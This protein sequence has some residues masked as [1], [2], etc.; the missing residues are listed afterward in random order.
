M[1]LT[2]PKFFRPSVKQ[3]EKVQNQAIKNVQALQNQVILEIL[4]TIIEDV[5]TALNSY[6][7]EKVVKILQDIILYDLNMR[8]IISGQL[9]EKITLSDQTLKNSIELESYYNLARSKILIIL[10]DNIL[11]GLKQAQ[12]F[13][14]NDFKLSMDYLKYY[15]GLQ[16]YYLD[17]LSFLPDDEQAIGQSMFQECSMSFDVISEYIKDYFPSD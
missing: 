16:N 12:K 6:E 11:E 17:S 10:V 14:V 9:T 15:R 1:K 8:K 2:V 4:Q 7:H 3:K 13:I 5:K